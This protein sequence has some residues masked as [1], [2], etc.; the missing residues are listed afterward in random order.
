MSLYP[1][2]WLYRTDESSDDICGMNIALDTDDLVLTNQK[3]CV[4]F[5]AYG[6]KGDGGY[7]DW[8]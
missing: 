7:T 8:T 4:V 1:S 2:E 6:V 5:D 3:V